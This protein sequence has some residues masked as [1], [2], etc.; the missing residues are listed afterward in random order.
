MN[1][2]A[3]KA[4]SAAAKRRAVVEGTA[5]CL[6]I[7]CT[8]LIVGVLWQSAFHPRA[9]ASLSLSSER[10]VGKAVVSVVTLSTSVRLVARHQRIP[11]NCTTEIGARLNLPRYEA[12]FA[13]LEA[14]AAEAGVAADG[15]PNVMC[16]ASGQPL[17]T[18]SS[19]CYADDG[20]PGLVVHL[21]PEGGGL[22]SSAAR[23]FQSFIATQCCT[24]QLWLWLDAGAF[25]QLPTPEALV[26]QF[27]L[28]PHH[29]R[30]F[31]VL[32]L[33]VLSL[34]RRVATRG[35]GGAGAE[36]WPEFAGLPL[37]AVPG[38]LASAPRLLVAAAWGGVL[39][40][41]YTIL[42]RDLS[43]LLVAPAAASASARANAAFFY[44][45][46][47]GPQVYP[48]VFHLGCAERSAFSR[49]ALAYAATNSV[50]LSAALTAVLA[51][52]AARRAAGGAVA[53]EAPPRLFPSLLFDPVWMRHDGAETPAVLAAHIPGVHNMPATF[54][55]AEPPPPSPPAAAA[56]A[57]F[58]GAF[59]HNWHHKDSIEA[60][61][62][63]WAA[64]LDAGFSAIAAAKVC[65]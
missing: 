62:R 34:W 54:A 20:V 61:P 21:V 8:A 12:C 36:R 43:P 64:A 25:A 38:P 17:Q 29:A 41:R 52:D 22:P 31:R 40:D 13:E 37:D 56:A 1:D 39:I 5:P 45:W 19:S 32:R 24:A 6:I 4:D 42:L 28:P 58:T 63:S 10:S 55:R 49:A 11:D 30:R 26:S 51:A 9:S 35:P 59:S 14:A 44:R 16:P 60:V 50:D 48:A 65:P 3:R 15:L 23:L 7:V 27:A 18:D 57:F 47:A 33:D 46:S 2:S 53:A